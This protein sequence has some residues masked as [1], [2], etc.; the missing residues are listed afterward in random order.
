MNATLPRLIQECS[1]EPQ[2]L[3]AGFDNKDKSPITS[4]ALNVLMPG[5]GQ[6]Y[7]Q[8]SLKSYF[9]LVASFINGLL[10]IF[11]FFVAN[12]RVE[13]LD[14]F[15]NNVIANIPFFDIAL[16]E[17]TYQLVQDLSFPNPFTITVLLASLGFTCFAVYEA[18]KTTSTKPKFIVPYK[19]E[20]FYESSAISFAI[21]AFLLLVILVTFFGFLSPKKPDIQVSQIEF[22][23]TQRVSK[24]PPPKK[25][26]RRAAKQS[27]DSGKNN[28]KKEV[29]PIT[30]PPGKPAAVP[31]KEV[32]A[33]SPTPKPRPKA[34]PKPAA[35]KPKEKPVFKP[36]KK[37][38]PSPKPVAPAKSSK[39]SQKPTRFIPAPSTFKAPDRGAQDFSSPAPKTDLAAATSGTA[40]ER[41]SGLIARLANIP[42]APSAGSSGNGGAFGAPGNP[43]ANPF[44]DQPPSLAAR[45]DVDFGPY[46]SSL[47]RKIK[48]TWRPPR[49]TETNRIV[50]NFSIDRRGNL[51]DVSMANPSGVPIADQAAITAVRK[52]APFKPLPASFPDVVDIEFTFDYNVFFKS[53]F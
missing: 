17:K 4:A 22:I 12:L 45:A 29:A 40:G 2:A 28:P 26:K 15:S 25:T 23:P 24:R 16:S 6:A 7:N 27:I 47:Q 21:H 41:S 36:F 11:L 33:P 32:K 42:R 5:L 19:K 37:T 20:N 53:R 50:V 1:E 8:E 31:K 43:G 30:K 35:I 3:D 48:L 10:L 34:K 49:G 18:V 39:P 44:A 51:V 38:V 46:M 9:F 52:A 13:T 14:D